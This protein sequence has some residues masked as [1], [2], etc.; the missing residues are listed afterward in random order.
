MP[1]LTK[2]VIQLATISNRPNLTKAMPIPTR[3]NPRNINPKN[4][5]LLLPPIFINDGPT[6]G[7]LLF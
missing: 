3:V 2:L 6:L 7:R 5:I 1:Y 4:F